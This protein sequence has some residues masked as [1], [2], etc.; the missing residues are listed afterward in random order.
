MCVRGRNLPERLL[1][2]RQPLP[3]ASEPAITP[4]G[5]RRRRTNAPVVGLASGGVSSAGNERRFSFQPDRA[6]ARMRGFAWRGAWVHR[7]GARRRALGTKQRFRQPS[8]GGVQ[9]T[10]GRARLDRDDLA[11][12]LWRRRAQHARTLC[13]D[14][15]VAG[16]GR[17]G[18]GAL[19][20]RPPERAALAALWH[21]G[22][23]SRLSAGHCARR[24]LLLHRHE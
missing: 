14:R 16:G 10:A 4:Q 13:R 24:D 17:P 21:R 15:G 3:K 6:A 22:A 7:R 12:A 18:R 1:S 9:P 8:V 2:P 19:D 5:V 11:Q 23:A 20:R